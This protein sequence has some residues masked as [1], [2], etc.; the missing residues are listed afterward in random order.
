MTDFGNHNNEIR[1]AFVAGGRTD[2]T[3]VPKKLT[4]KAFADRLSKPKVGAK[5]GS[6]Y[7]RGGDL[8]ERKR[9]DENLKSAE[10]IIL[11]GDSR[12]DPETGEIIAGAPPL[13]DVTEI[14]DKL[15]VCYIAHTSHSYRAEEH[16][17]KY[18]V[19]I[20]TPVSTPEILSDCVEYFIDTLNDCGVWLND[21]PEN[22]RWSQPWYLPRVATEAD[23]STFR[24]VSNF[25]A[26]I[27]DTARA[28]AWV[29]RKRAEDAAF[30]AVRETAPAPRNT[31]PEGPSIIEGFNKSHGLTWVRQE[32][33]NQGY[34]FSHFSAAKGT[35]RYIAPS[36]ETG[37]AGV[38]LFQGSQGD[39]C[40]Y[41][42]HGAHDPLSG[43]LTDPIG[44]FAA[45]HHGNDIKAAVRHIG[46]EQAG[47]DL[48]IPIRPTLKPGTGEYADFEIPAPDGKPDGEPDGKPDGKSDGP[49]RPL[50][51]FGNP[52]IPFV[53]AK[54]LPE[55]DVKYI[56][57]G[58][59]PAA[60]IS[61]IYGIP[62]AYKSFVA[63]YW[64]AM[65]AS[66]RTVFDNREVDSGDVIYV[67]GEGESGQRA[68]WTALREAYGLDPGLRI[69]FVPTALNLTKDD[70][71]TVELVHEIR[72]QCPDRAP[73]LV[74]IDTLNTMFGGGDENS[75]ADMGTFL[76]HCKAIHQNLNL[77][78]EKYTAVLV[79][80]HGGKDADRGARGSSALPA[81][82]DASIE[83]SND[84]PAGSFDRRG[85]IYVHKMK[86]GPSKFP[87]DFL[88]KGYDLPA[89]KMTNPAAPY[90]LYVTPVTE[91]DRNNAKAKALDNNREY[92]L[93]VQYLNGDRSC[94]REAF[95]PAFKADYISRQGGDEFPPPK[96]VRS[97]MN[98]ALGRL[99][100]YGLIS[101]TPTTITLL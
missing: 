37:E 11:D 3:L 36:S 100:A 52:L 60:G 1:L 85:H 16:F 28:T 62:G 44:M 10:L 12:M 5:D 26:A 4:L 72:R 73:K 2:V 92:R 88:V 31:V 29:A 83:V 68:R 87:V 13:E 61:I 80:H 8:V 99:K 63:L 6:Y 101:L 24:C 86:D 48:V 18:R 46:R 51:G 70:T 78:G 23:L 75:A 32:L 40:T 7:I 59:L 45:F 27:F 33:E 34:R 47:E 98:A 94:E 64:A 57:D 19:I 58:L 39:W 22:R 14:L 79:V 81:G 9:A 50:D 49:P 74:V 65:I 25:D 84:T 66:G 35:Y 53:W 90:S 43:R 42:H 20:P 30:E 15:G 41:S 56:I 71:D 38:V 21:V 77:E 96:E 54:D 82:I 76:K 91:A 93:L 97:N 69:G 95:L 67:V 55:I 89:T 17:W